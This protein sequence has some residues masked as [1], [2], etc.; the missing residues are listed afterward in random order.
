MPDRELKIGLCLSGGGLRA[1]FFHLGVVRFL[2]EAGFL[3]Q[4][5]SI[6]SVSGGSILAAHLVQHWD[7][8]TADDASFEEAAKPLIEF[9][10]FDLRG[11]I[12]RRWVLSMILF[13]VRILPRRWWSR[14]A[15]LQRYFE[16]ELYGEAT[17]STLQSAYESPR[18][19]PELHILTT[20]LTT[21]GLCSFDRNGFWKEDGKIV[22]F[23]QAG[24]LP[25]SLAVAASS[26]FPPLFPPLGL[27]KVTLGAK[28]EDMPHDT[29]YLTDG[30]VFDNLG[31]NKMQRLMQTRAMNV[32]WVILSDAG[33]DFDWEV[34]RGFGSIVSRTVRTTDIL[35]KRVGDFELKRAAVE[36][37]FPATRASMTVC[38]IRDTVHL[39]EGAVLHPAVQQKVRRIRTDLDG[40]SS[41][42]VQAL[43]SH[44]Y[45]I[46]R[47]ACSNKSPNAPFG[48]TAGSH[49]NSWTPQVLTKKVIAP[50]KLLKLLDFARV[51]RLG[52]WNP[53]DLA[54]WVLASIAVLVPAVFMA[55]LLFDAAFLRNSFKTNVSDEVS[56]LGVGRRN[57]VSEE[58]TPFRASSGQT[59]VGCDSTASAAVE[60]LLPPQAE[61]Q[62]APIANWTNMDNISSFTTS[63]A[64]M[65]DNRLM[66]TGTISGRRSDPLPFGFRNCAG[67]GHGELVL[68]GSYR[69]RVT[70]ESPVQYPLKGQL[71]G[72]PL[73]F[74]L[75]TEQDVSLDRISIEITSKQSGRTG[76]ITIPLAQNQR[77]ASAAS[78]DGRFRAVLNGTTLTLIPKSGS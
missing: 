5:A 46:A 52:F 11:R 43:I 7:R 22:K 49:G 37:E 72:A 60:W 53:K 33:A 29:E 6:C 66:A 44:G 40:F 51:R 32:D 77:N 36:A 56:I 27:S 41:E 35:M 55:S 45:A 14:T 42:E 65:V 38:S 16:S 12:I 48:P 26:A 62:G 17:L 63:P 8:Y 76:V 15:L 25:I 54:A 13:P 21:G 23:F 30:G 50:E 57:S 18:I 67:G 71:T 59:N 47:K 61:L 2:Q 73:V 75:P 3:K 64:P 31:I 70:R 39:H 34:A 20:S 58:L 19:A 28:D 1:T 24:L 74:T 10:R 78:D 4:T 68:S 9:G 69:A